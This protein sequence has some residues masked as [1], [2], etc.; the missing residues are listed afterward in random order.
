MLLGKFPAVVN[1]TEFSFFWSIPGLSTY[2]YSYSFFP[3][4]LHYSPIWLDL[5]V[6][7]TSLSSSSSFFLLPSSSSSSSLPSPLLF[8]LSSSSS[9]FRTLWLIFCSAVPL[10]CYPFS[11]QWLMGFSIQLGNCLWVRHTVL[12]LHLLFPHHV[13]SVL[14]VSGTV[15]HSPCFWNWCRRLE[16]TWNELTDICPTLKSQKPLQLFEWCWIVWVYPDSWPLF[17]FCFPNSYPITWK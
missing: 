13:L 16:I 2:L 9:S 7:F 3:A 12:F 10:A 15:F 4:L 1:K 6:S 11:F 17:L 8:L 14:I 5:T